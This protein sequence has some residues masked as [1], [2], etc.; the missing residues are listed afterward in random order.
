M[1][2]P[3]LKSD[4]KFTRTDVELVAKKHGVHAAADFLLLI[5]P[6]RFDG[7]YLTYYNELIE[8]GKNNAGQSKESGV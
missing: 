5:P 6:D 1:I 2:V 7:D 3:E 4:Y 8:R